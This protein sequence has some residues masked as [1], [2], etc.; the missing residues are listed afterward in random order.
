VAGVV[1]GLAGGVA[2]VLTVRRPLSPL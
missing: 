1:L 2:S